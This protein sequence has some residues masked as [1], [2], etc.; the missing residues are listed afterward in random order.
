R[1]VLLRVAKK[2]VGERVSRGDVLELE[3]AARKLVAHLV[4]HVVPDAAANLQR[5]PP[6]N[7]R[8]AVVELERVVAVRIRP[9]G[10]V[11]E[12][13]ERGDADR[14]DAPRLGGKRREAGYAQLRHD[15]AHVRQ[16]ASVRVEEVVVAEPE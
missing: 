3:V 7:P 10:V 5:M 8:Q 1:L 14:G 2:E 9:F 11:A 13:A 4:V 15:V 6:A 16:L 12:A